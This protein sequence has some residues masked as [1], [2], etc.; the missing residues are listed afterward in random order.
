MDRLTELRDTVA[1][2][3]AELEAI[4]NGAADRSLTEDEQTRFDDGVFV[5]NAAIAEGIDLEARNASIAAVRAGDLTV[6]EDSDSIRDRGAPN[7]IVGDK[8]PYDERYQREVGT[9]EAATRAIDEC[10]HMDGDAKTEAERKVIKGL[11]DPH[12]RG[13]DE[14]ILR[15]S[16][17]DYARG[18]FK[19]IGGRTWEITDAEGAALREASRYDEYRGLTLTAANGG[20]MIPVFLD[21]SVIV[22]NAGTRNPMRQISRVESVLTNVWNGVTSAGVTLAW[23][24]EGGDSTDVAATYEAPGITCYKASGTIPAT[25]E[26]FEDI[27]G[28]GAQVAAEIADA[29]DRLE[30]SAF[31]KGTGSTQPIGIVTAIYGESTLRETHATNSAFTATDLL[32]AQNLLPQRWQDGASW[33]GSLAYH[34]RVRAMGTDYYGQTVTLDQPVSSSILGRPAYQAS[35]MSTALST[36]TNTAF[37]Y[38]DFSN[39]LIADR[40]GISVEFIPH[41]FSTG[42]GLPNGRRGWY[43]HFRTGADAVNNSAFIVSTNPGA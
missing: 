7:V 6:L 1:F 43:C 18:F 4:H 24:T 5:R 11:S 33:V 38:G 20:A 34:N 23:G 22:T 26:A 2:L 40:V 39:Y 15:H 17:D 16:S 42:N 36:V 25:L 19:L 10:R 30:A 3:Q 35:D 8:D 32:D 29:K 14:Y 12:L 28:L 9:R 27:Q 31:I 21:P 13:M 41:L 37:V